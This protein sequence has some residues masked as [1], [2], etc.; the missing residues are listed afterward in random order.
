MT[1]PNEIVELIERFTTHRDSYTQAD[2]K[3]AR[4][5]TEFIDPFFKA[6][7]WDVTNE[8]GYAE[9]YKDVVHEDSIS[10][11]RATKAPDYSFRVGGVR[12][13]FV[14]YQLYTLTDKEVQI[15][16]EAVQR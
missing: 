7:G 2:Y 16:E 11:G 14:V 3:E 1:I 9:A 10:V 4:V 12:K 5:R 8:Q 13:F 15:V 6:L